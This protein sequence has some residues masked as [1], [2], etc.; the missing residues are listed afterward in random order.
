MQID[1]LSGFIESPPELS[2]KY[3]SG[4]AAK[5][6][7]KKKVTEL[8]T[9]RKY[10]EDND[11]S[12]SKSFTVYT[13]TEGKLH[14]SGNPIKLLQPHNLWGSLDTLGCFFEAGQY[15]RK[16]CGLFPGPETWKACQFTGPRY[17]R[18]DI[19]RSYRFDTEQEAIDYVR[20]VCGS[21][22][23]KHGAS[24]LY[25]SETAYFGQHSRR[26]SM[27]VYRK[28][29]EFMKSRTKWK[30]ISNPAFASRHIRW[31]EGVVR[32]EVVL[33]GL[34]IRE[35]YENADL[36]NQQT[37][38][39]IWQEKFNTIQFNDNPI[40]Q[41]QKHIAET[42]LTLQ[43]K[44]LLN[45]WRDGFDLREDMSKATFYRHRRK[46]LDLIGVDIAS[47]ALNNSNINN[48][49]SVLNPKGWDPEPLEG[50]LVE[51]NQELKLL[52]S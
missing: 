46:F 14:L 36:N 1:W 41:T 9:A 19:T 5:I 29:P 21:A 20:Y 6:D 8:R 24:K 4:W 25:G 10:I 17:T 52:Y 16:H 48:V 2:P 13:P 32:F 15:I 51:P 47:P 30:H 12:S 18:I 50:D 11:P 43:Q 34:E 49:N 45:Y 44:T 23:S 40:M 7:D 3:H 27:K 35:K 42:S 22:R 26:W 33:R 31:C 28:H 37:L 39:Q 38:K